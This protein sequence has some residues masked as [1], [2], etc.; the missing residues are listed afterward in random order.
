[1]PRSESTGASFHSIVVIGAGLSGLQAANKLVEK[2]PDLLLVEASSRLGGRVQ[3]AI[4]AVHS[5]GGAWHTTVSALWRTASTYFTL[6]VLQG[7]LQEVNCNLREF[8]WPDYWYFGNSRQLVSGDAKV[9]DEEL[10]RLHELFASV[11]QRVRPEPDISAAEWLRQEGAS[12]RMMAVADACYANDFGCSLHQL[13]LS[14]M[15]TE[16]QRWDSGDTY[17]IL[18]RPLQALVQ[19]LS[20]GVE[21]NIQLQWPV[22]R[23]E[24]GPEGAKLYGPSGSVVQCRRVIVTVPIM[25]LQQERIIFSPPLPAEKTAAISRIKMSNA[26]KVIFAFSWPF[27]PTGFFDV[28]CTDS[29]MPEFWVTEYPA[30]SSD[31]ATAGLCCMVGFVAG[32]R[33]EEISHLSQTAVITRSLAQLDHIF[34]KRSQNS[35]GNPRNMGLLVLMASRRGDFGNVSLIFRF[36]AKQGPIQASSRKHP[37]TAAFVR[38]HVEDWSRS[39]YIGGAYSYPSLGARPGDRE[40]LAASLGDTLF[41]AG[42]ATHPAVN[43]CMQAALETG[44]RAAAQV[45]RASE[46]VPSKL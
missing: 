40:S 27:W 16:N 43:P 17:L 41:F 20:K 6:S 7:L 29:F 46:H 38:A 5:I 12:E 18:D 30:T 23:I 36:I 26:V 1:M 35:P 9:S 10:E 2:Y 21:N 31:P 39:P 32:A 13:G 42:E 19:H 34:G 14:E 37:A 22:S 11:G 28:V 8:D 3:Q 33:A 24:Y 15:I 45:L 44:E 4:F 25:M